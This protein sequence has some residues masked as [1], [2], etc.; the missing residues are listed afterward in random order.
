MRDEGDVK[1]GRHCCEDAVTAD[2]GVAAAGGEA[3]CCC[4]REAGCRAAVERSRSAHWEIQL[5]IQRF[6]CRVCCGIV[7]WQLE[8]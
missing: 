7:E 3:C 5:K 1:L 6:R 4:S 2:T 8:V